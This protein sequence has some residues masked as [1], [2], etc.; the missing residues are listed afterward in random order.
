MSVLGRLRSLAGGWGGDPAWA[1]VY[2]FSVD[3]PRVGGP[4]WRVGMGSDLGLLLAAADE[5]GGLPSGSRVLDVPCGSG[6][7][8]RG[9]R[10]GQ[11]IEYVAADLAP[12]ML[13]RTR[14]TAERLGVA[15]QVTLLEADVTALPLPDEH[16]DR[17]LSLTGLHCFP[18]PHS[19]FAEMVR[20]L[21]PGG[22]LLG[23]ALLT[24]TGVRFEPARLI[25]RA[26]G[27]LGPMCSADELR[28]WAADVGLE[29]FTVRASGALAYFRGVRPTA[30]A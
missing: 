4:A 8:L 25:G 27:L 18:D 6:V 2:T 10:P 3:H 21:R 1:H 30:A 5:T 24:D 9:V 19:A 29:G 26:A 22:T 7:A 20:V 12:A 14:R 17:V 15:E 23:S 11:G 16:V 28:S 13:A